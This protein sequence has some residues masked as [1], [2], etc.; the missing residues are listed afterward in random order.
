MREEPGSF[1]HRVFPALSP[2]VMATVEREHAG[3]LLAA[4]PGFASVRKLATSLRKARIMA[5]RAIRLEA[6]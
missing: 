3:R 1:L 4:D 2:A 6:S 5:H